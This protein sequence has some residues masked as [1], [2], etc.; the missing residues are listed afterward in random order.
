MPYWKGSQKTS[1]TS[2]T[3]R[4]SIRIS[5]DMIGL[6]VCVAPRLIKTSATTVDKIHISMSPITYVFPADENVDYD[7][8]E[9]FIGMYA[10]DVFHLASI[11]QALVFRPLPFGR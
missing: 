3:S 2:S 8:P 5:P 6:S 11:Y 4:S 1:R 7:A 10:I 9:F